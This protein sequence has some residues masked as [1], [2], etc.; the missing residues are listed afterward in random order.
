MQMAYRGLLRVH[1][2][3]HRGRTPTDRLRLHGP[4]QC[5]VRCRDEAGLLTN[6][7]P[8]GRNTQGLR[9]SGP[10]AAHRSCP[11]QRRRRRL[12]HARYP[13]AAPRPGSR[14]GHHRLGRPHRVERGGSGAEPRPLHPGRCLV[15]DVRRF[16]VDPAHHSPAHG[17]RATRLRHGHGGGV[18]KAVS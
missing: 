14:Y 8:S 15:P 12:H 16:R 11:P 10:P 2:A 5:P 3:P 18:S 13:R 7:R 9:R 1:Q 6:F 4:D 17:H